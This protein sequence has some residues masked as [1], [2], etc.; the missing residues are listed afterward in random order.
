LLHCGVACHHARCRQEIGS[1]LSR[2]GAGTRLFGVKLAERACFAGLTVRDA[3]R[4][5]AATLAA[6]HPQDELRRQDLKPENG[7]VDDGRYM[8][9]TFGSLRTLNSPPAS[10]HTVHDTMAITQARTRKDQG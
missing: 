9:P 3:P 4:E 1:D 8:E 7:E 5:P 10:P 2:R 6:A